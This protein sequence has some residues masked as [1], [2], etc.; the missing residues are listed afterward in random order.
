M[1]YKFYKNKKNKGDFVYIWADYGI[2][3]RKNTDCR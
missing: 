2:K 1:D 3:K